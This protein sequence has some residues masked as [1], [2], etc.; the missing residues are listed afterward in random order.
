MSYEEAL[1]RIRACKQVGETEL[2]LSELAIEAR[3]PE[4]GQLTNQQILYLFDNQFQ[5]AATQN[6]TAT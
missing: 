4:I 6:R 5:D 3:P 1:E 2:D